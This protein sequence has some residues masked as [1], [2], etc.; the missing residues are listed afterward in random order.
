MA[1]GRRKGIAEKGDRLTL[2]IAAK[3]KFALELLAQKEGLT[4]STLV[5]KSLERPLR[6]GLTVSKKQGKRTVKIY[7]PDAAFD[8][9]TPD[10]LVN[11]A[12]VA[13]ELLTDREKV[14]WKVIKENPAFMHENSPDFK[15]IRL[16]WESI[17]TEAD[18][19]L[20]KHSG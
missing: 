16:R 6:E 9:L 4:L 5:M 3:D 8:P 20:D 17:Q 7:I 14:I 13:P 2:R 15:S 19:L 1:T 11:L 12:L 10:R 18:E